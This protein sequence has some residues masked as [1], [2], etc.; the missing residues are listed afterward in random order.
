ML[1][2]E[3]IGRAGGATSFRRQSRIQIEE[4]GPV[5][6]QIRM[7]PTLKRLDLGQRDTAS[8]TLIRDRR[9]G[10]SVADDPDTAV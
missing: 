9:I 2:L 6:L 3:A 7:D 5:G 4:V 10:E 8:A 1:G